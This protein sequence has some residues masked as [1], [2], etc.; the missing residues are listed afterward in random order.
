M[1]WLAFLAGLAPECCPLGDYFVAD[2]AGAGAAGQ[3]GAAVDCEFLFEVSGL[4]FGVYEVA[5][6]GAALGDGFPEDLAD[7][8]YEASGFWFGD[9]VSREEGMDFAAEEAF[10]G[11]DVADADD[12]GGV[13][14]GDLDGGG[15]AAEDVVEVAWGEVFAEGFRAEVAEEW[16]GGDLAGVHV[17][18]EAETAGIVVA[19][20]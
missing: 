16:M 14:E 10:R 9:F 4:A 7:G 17:H 19:E 6:G 20:L 11:V 13:H 15:P 8:G 12:G 3:A 18:A 2:G 1:I 5:Q